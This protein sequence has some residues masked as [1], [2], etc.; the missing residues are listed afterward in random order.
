[1]CGKLPPNSREVGTQRV[2]FVLQYAKNHY[3]QAIHRQIDSPRVKWGT[4][5]LLHQPDA[6]EGHVPLPSPSQSGGPH[7]D[8][9]ESVKAAILESVAALVWVQKIAAAATQLLERGVGAD[10]SSVHVEP[11]EWWC[12]K[13]LAVK[14]IA[15]FRY[16]FMSSTSPLCRVD[17]PEWAFNFML[18][19]CTQHA[20]ALDTIWPPPTAQEQRQQQQQQEG[21]H[22]DASSEL[23]A[24]SLSALPALDVSECLG[25]QLADEVR[26]LVRAHMR[27]I[28][29]QKPAPAQTESGPQQTDFRGLLD[30]TQQQGPEEAPEA[31]STLPQAARA[32]VSPASSALFLHLMTHLLELFRRWERVN[33]TSAFVLFRDFND[34]FHLTASSQD[35]A[36]APTQQPPHTHKQQRHQ[37]QQQ[38]QEGAAER[39][40]ADMLSDL[41][42]NLGQTDAPVGDDDDEANAAGGEGWDVDLDLQGEYE[43][44]ETLTEQQGHTEG[45]KEKAKGK[46]RGDGDGVGMLDYWMY[47]DQQ[48]VMAKLD[49]VLRATAVPQQAWQPQT[50]YLASRAD[51]HATSSSPPA[52]AEGLTAPPIY[53]VVRVLVDLLRVSSERLVGLTSDA[54][55]FNFT[56]IH[57]AAI[58]RVCEAL[59]ERWNAMAD[60]LKDVDECGLL[61]ESVGTLEEFLTT[62]FRYRDYIL[63]CVREVGELGVRVM[64]KFLDLVKT[65]VRSGGVRRMT[66]EM[67]VFEDDILPILTVLHRRL[68]AVTFREVMKGMAVAVDALVIE[69]YKDRLPYLTSP[70]ALELI[71]ANTR[72]LMAAFQSYGAV[73]E[74]HLPHTTD[75]L[76]LLTLPSSECQ[77]LLLSLTQHLD[78]VNQIEEEDETATLYDTTARLLPIDPLLLGGGVAERVMMIGGGLAGRRGNR[79]IADRAA[80]QEGEKTLRQTLADLGVSRLSL[81]EVF[82]VLDKRKSVEVTDTAASAQLP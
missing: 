59:K 4:I 80:V 7:L 72:S 81:S 51:E 22:Q 64:A 63:Q 68:S 12:F 14:P 77:V 40:L 36:D 46:D 60:P 42:A 74:R 45:E 2:L 34:N 28:V 5:T 24:A 17:R 55:L 48:F 19:L 8:G 33:V 58:G 30:K 62:D 73:P 49:E 13:A 1:V 47:H 37:Q 61:L 27:L 26:L 79:G 56:S 52:A 76:P 44:G 69:T 11:A 70:D 16:H 3:L 29:F 65:K 21:Q 9:D 32:H 35:T 67:G 53:R 41:K 66:R 38:Q 6:G 78:A 39:P 31:T 23:T 10:E 20:A 25:H 57:K 50:L 54:A 71:I 82:Q 75:L 15:A 43:Q 18:D